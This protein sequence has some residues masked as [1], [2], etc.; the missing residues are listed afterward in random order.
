[1]ALNKKE[2]EHPTQKEKRMG[3]II[4]ERKGAYIKEMHGQKN[5]EEEKEVIYSQGEYQEENDEESITWHEL[6]R[7]SFLSYYSLIFLIAFCREVRYDTW[8]KS[9]GHQTS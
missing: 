3:K 6:L 4:N 1:M 8:L 5:Y 9:H 2:I 7:F